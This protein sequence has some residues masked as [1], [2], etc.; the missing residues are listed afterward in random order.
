[1][2]RSVK[3]LIGYP[4][5]AE[6]GAVGKVADFLFDDQEWG[7]RYLVVRTGNWLAREKVLISPRDLDQP[8]LGWVGNHFP[9]KLTKEQIRNSPPLDTD[10]PVSRQYEQEYAK[11]YH[12]SM[13]WEGAFIWGATLTPHASLPPTPEEDQ[14]HEERVAKIAQSHLRSCQEAMGYSL[15]LRD[16]QMGDLEDFILDTQLWRL[17]HAIVDTSWLPGH[18]VL[19][20]VDW[21]RDFD[22]GRQT[23]EVD[24]TVE[25]VKH[26]P[27]FNHHEGVNRDYEKRLY[28]YY[29]KPCYWEE[30]PGTGY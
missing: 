26:S 16:G 21:F 15:T 10:A 22:W 6:D 24:L 25:Q 14:A 20:D 5:E 11:Y 23:A 2:L 19:V 1:M 13:Y 29:G 18:R 4:V 3:N 8:E 9:V 30:P 17:R 12:H 28:D 27:K 7:L